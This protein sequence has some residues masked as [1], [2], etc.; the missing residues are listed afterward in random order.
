M[1]CV[2][3]VTMAGEGFERTWPRDYGTRRLNILSRQRQ[4]LGWATG[5]A[6]TRTGAGAGT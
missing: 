1:R 3:A 2:G 4:C 5:C 6:W